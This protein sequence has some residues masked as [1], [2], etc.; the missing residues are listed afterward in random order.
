[1][2]I[3]A[4]WIGATLALWELHRRGHLSHDYHNDALAL[5][6]L[7]LANAGFFWRLLFSSNVWMPVGGGD[8]VSFLYPVYS[9]AARSLKAADLPL[10]NPYLYGGAPFAADNQSG[11]FYPL[12][13]AAFLLRPRLGYRT[14]E[15]QAVAHFYLAGVCAYLG[16]RY[17]KRQPLKRWAALAGAAAFMFSDLFVTHFGNLNMI[18]S[19]AWLPL[20]FCLFRRALDEKR[21]AL[22]AGAGVLL[23]FA[24]LAGHVQPLIYTVLALGLYFL[25]HAYGHRQSDWRVLLGTTSLLAVTMIVALGVA[26]PALLPSYEMS[27]LSLR[28]G[29]TYQDASQYSLPPAALVGLLVPGI[30]GRGPSGYW[31]PWP[32][33]EV[34]YVGILPLLLA[35]LALLLRRDNLTRFLAL[36]AVLALFLALGNFGILHG[37]LYRFVPGFNMIRAPAR[38]IYLLDF[39]LA[40]LAALGLDV[41]LRPIP[42]SS[43]HTWC[44]VLRCSPLLVLSVALIMLPVTY[45]TLLY[46]QDKAPEIFARLL[47]GAGGIVFALLLLG[48][49]V[50]ILHLRGRHRVHQF[51]L[52]LIVFMLILF[53]LASLGAYTEL[54][55]N[56]PTAGFEHPAAIAFLK[57]D[58][59]YYRIDTRTEVWDVWQPD[60][61]LLHG[62]FD[63]WGIHNPLVLADYHRYWEGLGSRSTPLYDFLN[64]KYVVGH[65]DVV[66]D[67]ERFELAF[68][69]DPTV[70]IYRNT[71][72]LPRAFVVHKSWSVPDQEQAF[73]AIHRTDF[74]PATMVVVEDGSTL[75]AATP[76]TSEARIESYSNNEIRLQASTSIPG[77]LVM[78]EVYYPGWKAEV[79]GHPADLQRANYA[80]RAVLLS[81]GAHQVR[82]YFQPATWKAGMLCSLFTWVMLA[83]VAL[84][85]LLSSRQLRV[86][87]TWRG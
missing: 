33:V 55:F 65:K 85:A 78:S 8:L 36:L 57:N 27:R 83:V 73:T 6:A 76:G 5:A 42:R 20:I 58:P 35:G 77:Y 13:L 48:C 22:A 62:I 86:Q 45:A 53:D 18:A 49:G 2:V 59:E 61:S 29:L 28:A 46:S 67:W 56:D 38:F 26:A 37:W 87:R 51:T 44:Q 25:Y 64:A 11:L 82:I 74:D 54:E 19:A 50:A 4:V 69:A 34:G 71:Q 43:R 7:A 9:F 32:R 3:I 23:G 60:L 47:T 40:A 30:F 41:L 72:V 66:L 81:P 75:T 68:D 31:G 24:A 52:G 15:L 1:M 63:V 84:R 70:N 12:N 17:I 80:F 14:M 21:F 39:A 10:W 79:D 16:F